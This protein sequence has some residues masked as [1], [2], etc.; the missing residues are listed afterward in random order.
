MCFYH[1]F[2]RGKIYLLWLKALN[3]CILCLTSPTVI[4]FF[5]LL[6]T[7][8]REIW[9]F[10]LRSLPWYTWHGT[11]ARN[12]F[13]KKLKK[14]R[15]GFA[16]SGAYCLNKNVFI[17]SLKLGG[18]NEIVVMKNFENNKVALYTALALPGSLRNLH[19]IEAFRIDKAIISRRLHHFCK[20][21]LVYAHTFLAQILN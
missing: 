17:L 2:L 21:R 4:T 12:Y 6:F 18:Y 15:G 19:K 7:Y 14:L 8:S 3:W 16:K 20:P 5:W 10:V 1:R 11:P 13:D 9:N